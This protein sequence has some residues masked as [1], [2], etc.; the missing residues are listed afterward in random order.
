M[1]AAA[2]LRRPVAPLAP[3][4][5]ADDEQ[6]VWLEDRIRNA[7]L[8]EPPWEGNGRLIPIRTTR[9]LKD[10]SDV[11]ANGMWARL[12]WFL[13]GQEACFLTTGP[14]KAA[15]TLRADAMFGWTVRE[16]TGP[17]GAELPLIAER[18]IVAQFAAAGFRRRGRSFPL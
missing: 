14:V 4:F 2:R 12:D 15:I 18:E 10:A 16:I 7:P 1:F 6:V 9:A 8:F 3:S 11:F 5:F 17:G 13:D